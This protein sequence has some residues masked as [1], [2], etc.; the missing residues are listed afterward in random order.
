MVIIHKDVIILGGGAAGLFCAC[1][2]GRRGRSVLVLEHN[3]QVGRKIAVSGGG[4]CNFTNWHSNP[5]YFV[6]GNPRF[7]VSALARYTPQDFLR[8]VESHQIPYHEKKHG[9][10][11]CDTSSQRIIQMLMDECAQARVEIRLNCVIQQ[12]EKNLTFRV[13][14]NQ[15]IFESQSLVVAT[16]GLSIAKLGATG[17]GYRAARQF[18]LALTEIRPGLVPLIFPPEE[19]AIW[20]GL[21]GISF[22]A[23]VRCRETEFT[24]NVLFTHKGLSGPAIL[25]ISSYWR[26]G[27]SLSLNLLPELDVPDWLKR[28]RSSGALPATLLAER[29]PRRFAQTWC[30]VQGWTRPLRQ[31][32]LKQI[33]QLAAQL[34]GWNIKP[35]GTEGYQKAEVTRGGV[36]TRELS[37]KTMEA[38]KVPNL[39][40]I[41]E[42]V[43]VTGHLGGHNFQWAW[44]SGY[45][46]G[47]SV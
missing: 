42:V 4:R 14:T 12:I 46:A 38:V 24:E 22:L 3:A 21:R 19:Q 23:G 40:F 44:S 17:L 2:A 30:G 45:C 34:Q 15:G 7:C 8:L 11:F 10:L 41:G 33:Q 43:D 9:Q 36:D 25:Q 39:F 6:S 18:G 1:E 28:C 26:E 29:L 32:S 16:G 5:G 47:Q 20:S 35:S 31:Y 27:D 37:P 13:Q